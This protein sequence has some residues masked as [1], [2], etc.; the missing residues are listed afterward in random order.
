M[1][2]RKRTKE[3]TKLL[4]EQRKLMRKL[5]REAPVVVERTDFST[6]WITDTDPEGPPWHP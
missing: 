5:Q 1:K 6:D 3:E 4:R 2:K